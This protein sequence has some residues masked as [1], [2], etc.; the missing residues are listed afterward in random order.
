MGKPEK[1]LAKAIG[2][3]LARHVTTRAA[4]SYLPF[5]QFLREVT[6]ELV[7]DL[8]MRTARNMQ[9]ALTAADQLMAFTPPSPDPGQ[10]G[11]AL[12]G[13]QQRE[14]DGHGPPLAAGVPR[15]HPEHPLNFGTDP[16]ET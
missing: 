5:D 2:R 8:D 3:V 7:R 16:R 13:E 1:R 6:A 4:G 10:A 12:A 14:Q 11:P 15:W 9:A